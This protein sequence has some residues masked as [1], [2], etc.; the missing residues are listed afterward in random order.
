MK[1]A[2]RPEPLITTGWTQV[3]GLSYPTGHP[4]S[5]LIDLAE[6]A[7]I[8]PGEFSVLDVAM[9]SRGDSNCYIHEAKNYW[10]PNHKANPLPEGTYR[11]T[12]TISC[13]G[14]ASCKFV[15]QLVNGSGTDPSSMRVLD[16]DGHALLN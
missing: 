11:F 14:R 2:D 1:W 6:V 4:Q 9:K 12:L 5:W 3:G 15:F 13:R 8:F 16:E 10:V 7:E